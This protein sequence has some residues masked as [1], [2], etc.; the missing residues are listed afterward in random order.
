MRIDSLGG[1]SRSSALCETVRL[2]GN[3]AVAVATVLA[4]TSCAQPEIIA[5]DGKGYDCEVYVGPGDD[6]TEPTATVWSI[7][8][9]IY[10]GKVVMEDVIGRHNISNDLM[11]GDRV[12]ITNVPEEHIN[13][14]ATW[15]Q[16]DAPDEEGSIYN[17]TPSSID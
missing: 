3:R 6:D 15:T 5:E 9:T 12:T 8:R 11:M 14:L 2:C 10:G 7:F 4:L 1:A 16:I 17:C 13:E